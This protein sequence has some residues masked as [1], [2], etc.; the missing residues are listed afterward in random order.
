MGR[1]G[2]PRRPRST[3]QI[4]TTRPAGLSQCWDADDAIPG[5]D[6][7]CLPGASARHR[8]D[9]RPV[10]D[11]AQRAASEAALPQV[12]TAYGRALGIRGDWVDTEEMWMSDSRHSAG[13][14]GTSRAGTSLART[15]IASGSDQDLVSE[16]EGLRIRLANQPVIEQSKGILMGYYGIGADAAF[17]VLRRWSSHSNRKL[18]DISEMIVATTSAE[19]RAGA[20]RSSPELIQLINSLNTGHLPP[21]DGTPTGDRARADRR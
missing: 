6:H 4:M 16:L 2:S 9:T 7:T 15:L 20:G 17:D 12:L 3:D 1:S 13:I 5:T 18:R 8:P 11:P 19:P 21:Q 10:G 14:I